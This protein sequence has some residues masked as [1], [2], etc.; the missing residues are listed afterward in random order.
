MYTL[1][2]C[3][4]IINK[5]TPFYYARSKMESIYIQSTRYSPGS[6]ELAMEMYIERKKIDNLQ[7]Y[8]RLVHARLTLF[9]NG[10]RLDRKVFCRRL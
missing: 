7:F 10:L 1:A 5:L 2:V 4:A 9:M 6:L 8:T 3:T